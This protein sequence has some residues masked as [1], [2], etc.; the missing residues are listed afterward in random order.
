MDSNADRQAGRQE[1]ATQARQRA[2]EAGTRAAELRERIVQLKAGAA[3]GG[4]AG[5]AVVRRDEAVRRDR[6]AHDSAARAHDRAAKS[7]ELLAGDSVPTQ[8][9]IYLRK[10]KEHRAAADADRV[11]GEGTEAGT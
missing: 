2:E 8:R 7:F 1:A 5:Q 9:V 11:H 10:A 3:R 4:D 6:I